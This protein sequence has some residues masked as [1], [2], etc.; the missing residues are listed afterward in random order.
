MHVIVN[1]ERTALADGISVADALVELGMGD[2]RGV[3]IELDDE[4]LEREA[5][6]GTTLTE[7]SRLEI[8][9]FVGG[10]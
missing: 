3:A 4:F 5:Y 6:G 7:H 8:V 2:C 9:R 1:G 10:G